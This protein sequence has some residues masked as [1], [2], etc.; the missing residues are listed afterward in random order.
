MSP[1][2]GYKQSGF[3]RELGKYAI[4]L[5]TQIKAVYAK[6][7]EFATSTNTRRGRP[8][9]RPF[10]FR[11]GKITLS[12]V[13]PAVGFT[14]PS[15]GLSPAPTIKKSVARRAPSIVRFPFPRGK[16]LGVRFCAGESPRLINIP[17]ATS[18]PFSPHRKKF[19]N[20]GHN[21]VSFYP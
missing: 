21:A 5:Y 6:I 12:K 2:G 8:I 16:G 7:G 13:K 9:G 20:S 11:D 4:D 1:F 15:A 14:L 17:P 10:F 19:T 18:P 3:G